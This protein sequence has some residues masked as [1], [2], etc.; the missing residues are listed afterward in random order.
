MHSR[1]VMKTWYCPNSAYYRQ[2][3]DVD[4]DDEKF[5]MKTRTE[6]S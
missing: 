5:R 2:I 1:Y 6:K 3:K 4:I